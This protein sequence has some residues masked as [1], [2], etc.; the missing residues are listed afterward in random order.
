[1]KNLSFAIASLLFGTNIIAQNV[2]IGTST[3]KAKLHLSNG[4]SGLNP[5]SQAALVLEGNNHIYLQFLNLASKEGGIMFGNTN[6][7]S[8]G[9]MYYNNPSNPEGLDFRTNGNIAPLH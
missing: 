6:G 7:V 5:H 3:P 8:Q 1:M 2:G 9:G 4:V